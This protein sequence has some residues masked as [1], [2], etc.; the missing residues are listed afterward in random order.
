MSHEIRTPINAIVGY[1]DL[2]ELGIAGPLTDGQ[3]AQLERVKASS[4]H[5]LGLVN[6]ILDLAKVESGRMRVARERA[7]MRGSVAEAVTLVTPQA[8]QR[9]LSIE[10]TSDCDPEAAY[11]GD[12]E[13]VSVRGLHREAR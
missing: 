2:L 1:T 4:Q 6:E 8:D 5:L 13:R 3:R 10:D 11:L 7:P 9:A 12:P